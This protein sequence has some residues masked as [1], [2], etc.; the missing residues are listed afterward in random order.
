MKKDLNFSNIRDFVIEKKGF[1]F[2]T[3]ILLQVLQVVIF[4]IPGDLINMV[5]GFVFNWHLGFILSFMGIVIGTI[6]VFYIARIFGYG[7]I[8]KII[9]KDKIDKVMNLLDSSKG[10]LGMFIICNLPFLPKDVLMYCAGLTP[11][12]AKKTIPLYCLCRIPGIIIWNLVGANVYDKSILGIII[13]IIGL[14][15]LLIGLLIIKNKTNRKA[16]NHK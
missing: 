6:I 15:T 7:F 16:S 10:F 2:L 11:L 3:Y 12:K 1:S 4:A 14:L 13:T 8:S 5:G 9:K